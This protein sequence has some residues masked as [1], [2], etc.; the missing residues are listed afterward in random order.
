MGVAGEYE[1]LDSGLALTLADCEFWRHHY[2]FFVLE[3]PQLQNKDL[4]LTLCTT[5]FMSTLLKQ[6]FIC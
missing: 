6:I 4:T 5:L 1:S 3:F 2:T